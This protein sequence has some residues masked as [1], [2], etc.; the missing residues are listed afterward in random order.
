[1]SLLDKVKSFADKLTQS[2][3]VDKLKIIAYSDVKFEKELG[4]FRVPFNPVALNVK[5]QINQVEEKAVGVAEGTQ[6]QMSIP[7]QDFAFEF[8]LDATGFADSGSGIGGALRKAGKATKG[9]NDVP[10]QVEKLL[11]L[12]Y[13]YNGDTHQSNYIKI[14]YGT[15]LVKCVLNTIDINYNLFAKDGKPL[16]AKVTMSFKTT[17]DPELQKIKMFKSSPDLSHIREIKQYDRFLNMSYQIYED[18]LL[19]VQV[20]RA[21]NMNRIRENKTGDRILFPPIQDEKK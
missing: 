1:M 10:S 15:L 12:V 2:G 16:R 18:N 14:S 13:T 11:K 19:Y 21:N 6:K 3:E 17:G 5:L 8:M 7:S 9:D 20:A 4:T